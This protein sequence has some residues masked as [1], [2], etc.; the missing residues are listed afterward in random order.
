MSIPE[1]LPEKIED[2]RITYPEREHGV[3]IRGSPFTCEFEGPVDPVD[4]CDEVTTAEEPWQM[5]GLKSQ[6]SDDYWKVVGNL[7]HVE[8]GEPVDSSKIAF[9]VAPEWVRIYVKEDCSAE[10]AAEFVRA[11]DEEYGVEPKF[12]DGDDSDKNSG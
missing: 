10:R 4:F 9:E 11:L 12:V 7:F 6:L 5:F 1:N 8:D 3:T 2:T